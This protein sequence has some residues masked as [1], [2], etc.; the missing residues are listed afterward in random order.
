MAYDAE[1]ATTVLFGEFVNDNGT[2][3]FLDDTWEWSG[4]NWTRVAGK[5]AAPSARDDASIAYDPATGTVVLFGGIGTGGLSADTWSWNGTAWSPLSPGSEPFS[6]RPGPDG[7]RLV[8]GRDCALR[9]G[10]RRSVGRHLALG[11]NHLGAGQP[12]TSPSARI[13]SDSMDY[14]T[15]TGSMCYSEVTTAPAI[16]PTP[17]DGTGRHGHSSSRLPAPARD[18]DTVAYDSASAN[19]VLFGGGAT[20]DLADNWVYQPA[21]AA[22]SVTTSLTGG[23]QSGATIS[24]PAGTSV[25][26][27]PNLW[28]ANASSAGGSVTYTLFS[29]DA[30]TGSVANARTFTVTDGTVPNSKAVA[31]TMVGTCYWQVSYSGDIYCA[32]R[33]RPIDHRLRI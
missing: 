28:G 17:G 20:T 7:L 26:D 1:N 15:A 5:G 22:T 2:G 9:G 27:S 32:F 3:S 25:T 29:D 23:S 33:R 21:A 16:K 24:V 30:C 6:S 10:Q 14:D 19:I 4:T 18:A 12:A 13:A 8:R 11:R 31:L